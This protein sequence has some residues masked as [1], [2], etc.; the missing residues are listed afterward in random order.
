MPER[1]FRLSA[2]Q[3]A[4]IVNKLRPGAP[5]P[6]EVVRSDN[7]TISRRAILQGQEK[8]RRAEQASFTT[9]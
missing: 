6:D 7:N 2:Q 9:G 1:L 3:R 8:A 5:L 4:R